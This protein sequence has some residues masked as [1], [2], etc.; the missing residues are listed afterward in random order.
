MERL[1][2]CLGQLPAPDCQVLGMTY[3]EELPAEHIARFMGTTLGNV[4]VRRHRAM[5]RLRACRERRRGAGD[6]RE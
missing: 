3:F 2:A 1:F 5:A 4:R 6:T